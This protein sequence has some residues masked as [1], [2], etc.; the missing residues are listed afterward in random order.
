MGCLTEQVFQKMIQ[1]FA[2]DAK[3]IQHFTKVHAYASLI[4]KMEKLGKNEQQVLEI[5]A[6]THDIGIRNAEY[7]YGKCDGPLQE[8]EGPAPARELLISLDAEPQIIE[9]V[10]YLI[11]H[12]HTYSAIVG[13][14]YQILVEADF[15]VNLYED[16]ATKEAVKAA[17]DKIF[18]TVSGKKLCAL[19]FG[20]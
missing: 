8:Q 20:L 14:D 10:I 1:Y 9:R 13:R 17:Y 11:A 19:M 6:L 3:R 4:G 12:H 2:S 16:G 18:C 5:A 7:K 15:L